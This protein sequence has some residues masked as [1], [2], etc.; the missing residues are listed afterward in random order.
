MTGRNGQN[1][2]LSASN[3]ERKRKDRKILEGQGSTSE[4]ATMTNS[5]INLLPI[6]DHNV[7]LELKKEGQEQE[8]MAEEG[9]TS[10]NTYN[11]P[12]AVLIIDCGSVKIPSG[13]ARRRVE[14]SH[15]VKYTGSRLH[16]KLLKDVWM[17]PR[18]RF[19]ITLYGLTELEEHVYNRGARIGP[20]RQPVAGSPMPRLTD[21]VIVSS[22][23]FRLHVLWWHVLRRWGWNSPESLGPEENS[24]AGLVW[25]AV[26]RIHQSN[27]NDSLTGPKAHFT[28]RTNEWARGR[29]I[30]FSPCW[31]F[32][33]ARPSK[34]VKIETCKVG[35]NCLHLLIIDC[36]RKYW[37][38][39]N[40][41]RIMLLNTKNVRFHAFRAALA[42]V[43][44]FNRRADCY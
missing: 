22:H 11:R 33:D 29:G 26:S 30:Y 43:P 12:N 41:E 10:C 32:A 18:A 14:W 23:V 39:I 16:P 37:S 19:N 4:Q 3:F 24:I 35:G 13:V 36:V 40:R 5:K 42:H 44:G 25:W 7:F 31:I 34:C 9:E 38:S 27:L 8:E 21:R 17:Y 28:T 2:S 6:M 1:W 15:I 20:N